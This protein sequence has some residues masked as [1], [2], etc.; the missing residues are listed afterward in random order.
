M[1]VRDKC[2]LDGLFCVADKCHLSPFWR[3]RGIKA[4]RVLGG[5]MQPHLAACKL[6]H[7]V[8]SRLHAGVEQSVF[9]LEPFSVLGCL[10]V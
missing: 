6:Q 10:S 3:S 1:I 8:T 9:V 7:V 4:G 5:C 2:L